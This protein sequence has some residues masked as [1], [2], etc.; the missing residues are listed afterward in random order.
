MIVFTLWSHGF[1]WGCWRQ[2][3]R[4]ISNTKLGTNVRRPLS[5]QPEFFAEASFSRYWNGHTLWWSITIF[6]PIH[7]EIHGE[8]VIYAW[9]SFHIYIYI[10]DIYIYIYI[11]KC[12]CEFGGG[13]ILLRYRYTLRTLCIEGTWRHVSL[14]IDLIPRW[15]VSHCIQGTRGWFHDFQW[16]DVEY[17]SKYLKINLLHDICTFVCLPV[18]LSIYRSIYLS[19]LSNLSIYLS[20]SLSIYLSI[21]ISIYLSIL[22]FLSNLSFLSFLSILSIYLSIDLSFYLSI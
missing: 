13:Y 5:E 2:T 9:W 4:W 14:R 11:H 8:D 12:M 20:L 19:N 7:M 17:G 10:Y 3:S 15:G 1:F 18:Y 16:E 6:R 22:S 21:Y